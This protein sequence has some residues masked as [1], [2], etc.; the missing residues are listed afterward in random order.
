MRH[1]DGESEEGGRKGGESERHSGE[2]FRWS[3]GRQRGDSEVILAKGAGI[4]QIAEFALG[5]GWVVVE[6]VLDLGWERSHNL[7]I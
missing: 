5:D 2:P 4:A 6:N 3:M 7:V 1:E